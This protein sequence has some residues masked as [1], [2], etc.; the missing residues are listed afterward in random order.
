MLFAFTA[1]AQEFKPVDIE[2][3]EMEISNEASKNYYPKLIKKFKDGEEL[4][5]QQYRLLYYGYTFQEGYRP[6]DR[7]TLEPVLSKLMAGSYD[8]RNLLELKDVTETMLKD[9][10][11]DLRLLY[12]LQQWNKSLNLP[13]EAKLSD[14]KYNGIVSAIRSSGNGASEETAFVI[15][16]ETDK[17]MFLRALGLAATRQESRGFT[18]YIFVSPNESEVEGVYF[19]IERMARV[20]TKQ[21][22]IQTLQVEDHVMPDDGILI[23]SED[24]ITEFIPAG[25]ELLASADGDFDNDGDQ[26]WAAVLRQIGEEQLAAPDDK[27]ERPLIILERG[28]DGQLKQALRADKLVLCNLCGGQS[29]DPFESI[30]FKDGELLISHYGGSAWKWTRNIGLKYVEAD[31]EWHISKDDSSTWHTSKPDDASFVELS[32]KDFGKILPQD[33]DVYEGQ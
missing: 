9:N 21:L 12:Y 27:L 24:E 32:P 5:R 1:S 15:N 20:G 33:F 23:G 17:H 3:I 16:Y 25:F 2:S 22:G 19:E 14:V 28:A 6:Y 10:P 4:T 30:E 7:H 31:R 8:Q 13:E 29:G 11:F 18:D 26:D